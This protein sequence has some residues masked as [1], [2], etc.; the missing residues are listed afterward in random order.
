M[1]SGLLW[2]ILSTTSYHSSFFSCY[3]F[4]LFI[5]HVEN[6]LSFFTNDLMWFI[7]DYEWSWIMSWLLFFTTLPTP[8]SSVR[9]HEDGIDQEVF[10]LRAIC[11][12]LCPCCHEVDRLW[13]TLHPL[14]APHSPLGPRK[15]IAGVNY[16]FMAAQVLPQHSEAWSAQRFQKAGIILYGQHGIPTRHN[17]YPIC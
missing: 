9:G 16:W 15:L 12:G 5:H 17:F 11:W 7:L 2:Q 4:L 13:T 3:G 10:L 14:L 6:Q 1:P 8:G